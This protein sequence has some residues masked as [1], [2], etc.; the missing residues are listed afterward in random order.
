[1]SALTVY[2]ASAGSGKTFSLTVEYIAKILKEARSDGYRHI[3]AVTFT[4]KA[5]AEM[6]TR[7]LRELWDIAYNDQD[8]DLFCSVRAYLKDINAEILR[9]R[10]KKVLHAIV[11]DYDYFH[12]KTIDAFFQSLLTSLAH[13]LGLSAGFKVEIDDEKVLDLAV[14]KIMTDL[15]GRDDVKKWI[16][17]YVNMRIDECKTWDATKE[18][19]DLSNQITKE[20]FLLNEKSLLKELEDSSNLR[21]Y[22]I[23]LRALRTETIEPLQQA[24]TSF[25]QKVERSGGY[26][27]FFH[28]N[29]INSY[30]KKIVEGTLD[31]PSQSVAGYMVDS[32]KWLKKS[33][34][35]NADLINTA[36]FLRKE[37]NNLENCRKSAA[38]IV[39][40]C[41]LTLK[42]LNALGLLGVIS[43]EVDRINAENN[44]FMLAMTPILFNRLVDGEDASFVFEKAG[45]IFDHIM[46][47]EFQDTSTLQWDNFKMLLIEKMSQG[48]DCLL[49]GDVKQ[50]IY[51]FRNGD[52]NILRNIK[53]EFRSGDLQV[54]TLDTNYR[55][56][57]NIVKFNNMVFEKAP[58]FLDKISS[59]VL[60]TSDED[61]ISRIYS[62]AS[63]HTCGIMG[64]NVE[65]IYDV[66][67]T[68][69]NK[70]GLKSEWK[71]DEPKLLAEKINELHCGGVVYSN[72]AILVRRNTEVKDILD[73]FSQ[74]YPNI[75][76][77]SDEAFVLSASTAV[78]VVIHALRYLQDRNNT[79]SL[80]YVYKLT[81]VPN[82][83]NSSKWPC[84]EKDLLD[85]VSAEYRN[86]LECLKE[87]PLYELCERLIEIF[88][89]SNMRNAAPYLYCLLD[90]VTNYLEDGST[91]LDDFLSYWDETLY[92]KS[93]PAGEVEGV[94]ILTIHKSKGLSF[95]TVFI[96]YCNWSIEKDNMRDLMWC[97]PKE[98]PY[99]QI[100]IVPIRPEKIMG[101]SIYDID[102]MTEHR[103]RR[104]ENLN[105]M[106]VAFTRA[107]KNLFI[108]AR[109]RDIEDIGQDATM[110]E[111]LYLSTGR[112]EYI[113]TD[114]DWATIEKSKRSN[115]PQNRIDNPLKNNREQENV[116]MCTHKS[117]VRFRQSNSAND[118]LSDNTGH[119]KVSSYIDDGKVMH[120]I[121]SLL[122]T[123]ADLD[124]AL[125]NLRNAGV[126]TS[127]E[128]VNQK[129]MEIKQ[130]LNFARDK[131]WFD[132]SW[133][134]YNERNIISRDENGSL[135]VQRPDRVMTK[136]GKTVVI[137][138][139]FGE[140]QEKCHRE[141]V[142]RYCDL[143]K[144]MGHKNITGY[145]WYVRCN[146]TIVVQS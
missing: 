117:H 51:R 119:E 131:G 56:A 20:I 42:F 109:V 64:G 6:K 2:N 34:K 79:A 123:E 136:D 114:G 19:R 89:L 52:W 7:I 48:Q 106:Y 49:V 71:Q 96:P 29:W 72:M 22:G 83:N 97:K 54:K 125:K 84:S 103:N 53:N 124:D 23:K 37:L 27:Q 9:Q 111:L 127:N 73:Y 104:I 128:E 4:N 28:G 61:Y 77:I 57:E 11:H 126:L 60:S 112:N 55:S 98:E 100:P 38:R 121:F 92:R 45:T 59:T 93:I 137:D 101:E 3:L 32:E 138:F 87:L 99:N 129:R 74:E 110:G 30:V 107:V 116:S 36:D 108:W 144:R 39:N 134:L 142:L 94:R 12:V 122:R 8:T 50:G 118:F 10:A 88:N 90:E 70:T 40:S 17:S 135:L 26:E 68:R 143:L 145:L 33:D 81:T 69:K 67:S 47:D 31:E 105:L 21:N 75:P 44:R 113:V 43:K 140:K 80:A 91:D 78:Q 13:E 76:L 58:K 5:T 1:M 146:K 15:D 130:Y 102:Y 35:D 115:S 132:G 24:A 14:D 46:I 62:D 133:V 95:H 141:Q 86:G 139:K 16:L 85:G 66:K 120:Q 41:D 65:V 18:V 25:H 82:D 63:Q